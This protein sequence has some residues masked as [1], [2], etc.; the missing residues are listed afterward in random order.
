MEKL[1]MLKEEESRLSRL[2]ENELN[3]IHDCTKHLKVVSIV[4]V[5][6]C[7]DLFM[8]FDW[9]DRRLLTITSLTFPF[10]PLRLISRNNDTLILRS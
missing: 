10:S 8:F 4:Q 9:D 5:G 2:T 7:G 1:A 6:N 3:A